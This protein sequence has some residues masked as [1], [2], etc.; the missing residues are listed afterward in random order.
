MRCIRP[1]KASFGLDGNI[2]FSRQTS[3]L[4][5]GGF[6]FGCRKCL[7]CRL[8]G[9]REKAL[10]AHHEA[11]TSKDSIF[12]T[13]TYNEASLASPR[14]QY[15]DFQLFMKSLRERI[16][17]NITC[18]QLRKELRVGYM[19]TG[20]YG[21]KNKRPHWHALLFNFRPD[22]SLLERTTDR[23]DQ[24]YGS[25]LIDSIWARGKTEFGEVSIDSASYV[26]RY[27]AK[28]LIHGNDQDHDFHPVHRTSCVH[29]LGKKWI[30]KNWAQTFGLGFCYLPNGQ[31]T[32][33]PR[34]YCD[35]LKENKP[36][37]WVRYVTQIRPKTIALAEEVA[38]RE[39]QEFE[40]EL[41]HMKEQHKDHSIGLGKYPLKRSTVKHTILKRKFEQL[42][43]HLKL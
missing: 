38:R 29:A 13:L 22:D 31:R 34:Y 40:D 21:D 24:I 39:L 3:S 11:L 23:G 16:T 2:S 7:P 5:L 25:R 20:E 36:D 30:E 6:E 19:V 12:L 33:I 42:Q 14:L 8:S 37:E 43:E 35:W 27:A 1:I 15:L 28:K 26:A 10:R 18:P 4:E 41:K 9:A 32:G 17:R